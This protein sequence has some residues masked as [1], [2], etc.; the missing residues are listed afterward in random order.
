MPCFNKRSS[1]YHVNNNDDDDV[2][3]T[4]SYYGSRTFTVPVGSFVLLARD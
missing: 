1:S 3:V 4:S 2:V